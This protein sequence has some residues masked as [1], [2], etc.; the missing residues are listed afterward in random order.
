MKQLY[1]LIVFILIT[2]SSFSQNVIFTDPN[3]KQLFIKPWYDTNNDGEISL[4]EALN[5]TG[6]SEST[7]FG[8]TDLTGIA[9]MPN[10]TSLVLRNNPVSAPVNLTSNTQLTTLTL[11]GSIP[12]LNITGLH[13]LS[14]IDV[15]GN[16]SILDTSSKSLLK[17]LSIISPELLTID[18]TGSPILRKVNIGQS[19]ITTLNTTQNPL[20]E[21]LSLSSNKLNNIDLTQNSLLVDLNLSLNNLTSLDVSQ[22]PLLK[23][24]YVASNPVGTIDTSGNPALEKISVSNTGITSLNL[25]LNPLLK[26]VGASDNNFTN[27][28]DLSNLPLLEE[29][30][31]TRGNLKSIDFKNNPK[32]QIVT[33]F[34]NY[35]SQID[36]SNLPEL[37]N[38]SGSNNVYTSI[39]FSNNPNLTYVSLL[40]NQN[41]KYINLKNGNNHKIQLQPYHLERLDN[42]LGICIDDPNSHFGSLVKSAVSSS[43]IIT[44]NCALSLNDIN[45]TD[46]FSLYPNPIINEV[47]IKTDYNLKSFEIYDQSGQLIKKDTFKQD[48]NIVT[49]ESFLSGIYFI[50]ITT[51]HGTQHAKIIKK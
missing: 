7:N 18:I 5:I 8:I 36:V 35:I 45:K 33:I 1:F 20:L 44:S 4:T 32:L 29:V 39:D 25:Q 2:N 13:T 17:N 14:H 10:L 30:V 3:F 16:F 40:N 46:A 48:S 31:V 19:K 50:K 26:A 11:H 6:I 28:I 21:D 38:F 37:R 27:G 47:Y 15:N 51:D 34:H 22:N 41:L 23:T 49:M 43:V 12:A 24:L 42:L 9:S